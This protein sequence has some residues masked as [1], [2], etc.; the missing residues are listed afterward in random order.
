MHT[1]FF[2]IL[3]QKG[4]QNDYIDQLKATFLP[5]FVDSLQAWYGGGHKRD[6]VP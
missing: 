5:T 3:F 6:H 2:T 1:T 4:W